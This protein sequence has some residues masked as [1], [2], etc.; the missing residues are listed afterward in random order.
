MASTILVD[1]LFTAYATLLRETSLAWSTKQRQ[2]ET[3]EIQASASTP[4]A[5]CASAA[6]VSQSARSTAAAFNTAAQLN[7]DNDNNF[8]EFLRRYSDTTDKLS[9]DHGLR[10]KS[11]DYTFNS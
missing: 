5:N 1:P 4:V 6:L 8:T 7:Q 9:G 2:A 11:S 3:A 10:V